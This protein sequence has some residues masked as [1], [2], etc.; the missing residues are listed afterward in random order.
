MARRG[1]GVLVNDE[2]FIVVGGLGKYYTTERC[3]LD[4]DEN[5]VTCVEQQ[6]QLNH[7]E[8]YPEMHLVGDSF[9]K[10]KNDTTAINTQS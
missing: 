6:P 5:G 2:A 3:A 4:S 9:C 7:Y 1:H 10:D 8:L